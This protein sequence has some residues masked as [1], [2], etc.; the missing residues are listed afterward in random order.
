[1]GE[2]RRA[3]HVADGVDALHRGLEPVV[4]LDEAALG[5][6]HARSLS[7]MCSM[8]GARPAA[9]STWSNCSSFFSPPTS[10]GMVTPDLVA[11]TVPSLAPTIDLDAALLERPAE[12][13]RAVLVLEREQARHHFEQRHLGAEGV[14][15]VGELAAHGAGADHGDASSAPSRA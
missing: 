13:G 8:F 6:L 15:D 2:H 10:T 1:V 7:P 9:T 14:E 5:G 12:L 4:D 11:F 3:G